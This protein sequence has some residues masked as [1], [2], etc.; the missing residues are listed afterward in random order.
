LVI[1]EAV[2]PQPIEDNEEV[3]VVLEE[4]KEMSTV[5]KSSEL[6]FLWQC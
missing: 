6:Q 2:D 5:A 3:L 1:I 4:D